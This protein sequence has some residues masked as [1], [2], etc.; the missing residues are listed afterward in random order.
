MTLILW[1]VMVACGLFVWT[2]AG[3]VEDGNIRRAVMYAAGAA[4]V[5]SS[6]L[7]RFVIESITNA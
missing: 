6:F 3:A 1:V 7:A 4:F 5:W 2:A